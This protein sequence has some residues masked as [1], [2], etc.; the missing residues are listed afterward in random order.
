[1]FQ[2]CC[3]Q[4]TD[5][6]RKPYTIQ[7]IQSDITLG[8]EEGSGEISP[9]DSFSAD[10]FYT[11][12][13][14]HK[15][16]MPSAE[17]WS[18]FRVC[19]ENPSEPLGV[20]SEVTQSCPT[21]CDP[22]GCSLPGSSVHGI[23]Q[24]RVLEWDAISQSELFSSLTL[25]CWQCPKDKLLEEQHS[26]FCAQSLIFQRRLCSTSWLGRGRRRG[27]GKERLRKEREIPSVWEKIG[28]VTSPEVRDTNLMTWMAGTQRGALEKPNLG[29]VAL[30]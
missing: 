16:T 2:F 23:F 15:L 30:S 11:K 7:M 13:L 19:P 17:S 4:M 14:I 20:W 9:S 25:G 6:N 22:V 21:L 24:A 18:V 3:Q 29:T 12:N 10:I 28:I 27:P 26:F 8:K 5:L 1:M